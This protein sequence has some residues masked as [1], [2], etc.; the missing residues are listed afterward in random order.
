VKYSWKQQQVAEMS[1]EDVL[2]EQSEIICPFLT[3]EVREIL[4]PFKIHKSRI[5]FYQT[6]I[7]KLKKIENGTMDDVVHAYYD[8]VNKYASYFKLFTEG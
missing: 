5:I 8:A 7:R 4:E 6:M 2:T 1:F 3:D